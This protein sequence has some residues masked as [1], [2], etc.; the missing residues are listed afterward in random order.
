MKNK[1]IK[2]KNIKKFI[3]YIFII[4]CILFFL[5][6]YLYYRFGRY[7]YNILKEVYF[8]I[9]LNKK[10][11]KNIFLEESIKN[12]PFYNTYFKNKSKHFLNNFPILNKSKISELNKNNLMIHKNK[13][14]L[15]DSINYTSTN[16]T[17]KNEII[18]KQNLGFI[19]SIYY[20]YKLINENYAIANC[21][22][23]SSGN[24]F[25]Q[26][27]DLN[28]IKK[29]IYTF[30]K[31]WVN[32]GWNINEK[33]YLYYFHSSNNSN[34][35]QNFSYDF[36]KSNSSVLDNKG[37]INDESVIEFIKD[38]NSFKP[39]LIVSYPNIIFRICQKIYINKNNSKYKLNYIPKY[40]DLSADMLYTCQYNFIKKIFYN[41]DIRLSYGTIEFGQI[42]QQIPNKMFDYIVFDNISTVENS[43][44]NQLIVTNYIYKTLPIIR[45]KIDDYGEVTK[46]NDKIIIKNLIGKKNK[47]NI[48]YIELDNYINNC[49][50][51]GI[52]NIRFDNNN[53]IFISID[54][55]KYK[56]EIYHYMS[57]Y[58]S[59]YKINIIEC[60]D[61]CLTVDSYDKKVTTFINEYKRNI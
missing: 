34:I 58:N 57:K 22:G 32:M 27:M 1:N 38:I 16:W 51:E 15:K 20:L 4:L 60:I 42:A 54:N 47:Y 5:Y 13:K 25:Y 18:K 52:I 35:T 10:I 8:E 3:I 7:I 41:C 53:N 17:E 14:L 30:M 33:I 55:K 49:K 21:T 61:D 11:D 6:K 40:M 59:I 56:N 19:K 23:G 48:D 26:W 36:F 39:E 37:D 29:G 43:S 50:Y 46:I 12:I 44:N 9:K 24:Y 28:D 45:Y 2:N 31:C